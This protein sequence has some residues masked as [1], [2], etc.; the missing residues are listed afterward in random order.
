MPLYDTLKMKTR[1]VES[2]MN[3]DQAQALVEVLSD[4]DIAQIATKADIAEV[5]TDVAGMRTDFAKLEDKVDK[6][7]WMVG[8]LIVLNLG[9]IAKL[10]FT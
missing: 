2:G 9:I 10:L 1:L 8:S 6:L 3:E 7:T 4:E 5:R